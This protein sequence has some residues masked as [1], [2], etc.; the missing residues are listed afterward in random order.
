M[1]R[2]PEID[3]QSPRLCARHPP[4]PSCLCQALVRWSGGGVR[5]CGGSDVA[6]CTFVIVSL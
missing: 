2:L 4:Q 6:M 3:E 1:T 5:V